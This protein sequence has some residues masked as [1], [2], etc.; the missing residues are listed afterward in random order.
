MASGSPLA[1]AALRRQEERLRW[2]RDARFGLFIHWGPASVCGGEISWCRK[3][4]PADHPGFETLER[5]EYDS[6]YKRFNPV[7]FDA[8][9]W[10]A[11]ARAAGMKYVVFTAKHHDGF[12]N[13]DTKLSDYKITSPQC[14]FRRDICREIADAAHRHG[15]KL[16]WYYST[17]DWWHKDYLQ[18][19]NRRYDEYYRGQ[20][21]ELLTGYGQVDVMW[22]DHISGRW[23]GYDIPALF[24][25]MWQLQPDMVVNNRA[26]AWVF[27]PADERPPEIGPWI[28]GDFDT[29]EQTLGAFQYGRAWESCITLTRCADGGGWSYRP[30]GT[31]RTF[32]EALEMLVRCAGGDG[33]LLLNVGP[34]PTGRIAPD[35]AAVLRQM[36]QWLAVNGP[37]IYGTRG[38]PFLPAGDVLST[39][40]ADRIFV[41]LLRPSAGV[42]RLPA[43]APRILSATLPAGG[44]V[45]VAQTPDGIELTLSQDAMTPPCTVVELTI[46]GAALAISPR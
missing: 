12:A 17:R 9:E 43:I 27:P 37:A 6:L 25:M 20:I 14:P 3:G 46:D 32:E 24:E 40:K 10:M 11:L 16:G 13:W 44:H 38:G 36:G 19:D 26:A 41:H 31:T 34:P 28:A 18:G 29:P 21:R 1:E 42:I 39:R 45:A 5:A 22:F 33:N 8:D 30:D 2:W 35:Q 15:L 23:S 7:A 4:H